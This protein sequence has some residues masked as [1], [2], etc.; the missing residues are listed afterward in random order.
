MAAGRGSYFDRL[1]PSF[2][3]IFDGHVAIIRRVGPPDLTSLP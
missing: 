1:A 3:Y 2:S